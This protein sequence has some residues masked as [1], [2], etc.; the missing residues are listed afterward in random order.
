MEFV[1]HILHMHGYGRSRDALP[2]DHIRPPCTQS[3]IEL[4]RVHPEMLL[5]ADCMAPPD[6]PSDD[7]ILN[8]KRVTCEVFM[9]SYQAH[10]FTREVSVV[11]GRLNSP[12]L[13]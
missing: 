7:E 8:F 12:S 4:H 2:R 6:S 10:G 11:G 5:Q 13:V 1:I 3:E 9:H